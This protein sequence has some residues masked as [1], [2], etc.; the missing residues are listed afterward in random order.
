MRGNKLGNKLCHF[1]LER[2]KKD[3]LVFQE[4]KGLVEPN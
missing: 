4:K 1:S 2:P 3:H